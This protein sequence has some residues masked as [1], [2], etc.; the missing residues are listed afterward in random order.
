MMTISA[1]KATGVVTSVPSDSPDDYATLKDL[2][3]KPDLRAK[4]GITDEM[5]DFE[6]IP[7]I[8]CPSIRNVSAVTIVEE[9]K[10][11]S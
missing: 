2:K 6:A 7:I 4:Y 9:M 10:I 3:N 5:V 1:D 8:N 11:K